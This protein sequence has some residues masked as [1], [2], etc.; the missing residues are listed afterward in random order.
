MRSKRDT[1]GPRETTESVKGLTDDVIIQKI[2]YRV[3]C[4]DDIVLSEGGRNSRRHDR[5]YVPCL[6]RALTLG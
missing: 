2:D 1:K 4:E 6:L 3:E 5:V